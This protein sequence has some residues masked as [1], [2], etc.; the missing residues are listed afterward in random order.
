[1]FLDIVHLTNSINLFESKYT[2]YIQ[3]LIQDIVELSLLSM[4][5]ETMSYETIA[6]R[7]IIF[8]QN[9]YLSTL[10]HQASEAKQIGKTILQICE[11]VT[12]FSAIDRVPRYCKYKR[13]NDAEHSFMLA[14]AGIEIGSQYYP[15]LDTGL[16]GK[17]ALVHDFPEL[18]TGDVATFDLT[19]EQLSQK[20]QNE[21]QELPELLRSL[22]PHLADLL[23]I[24]EEQTLPEAQF[25]KHLDKLLPN[26]V[27][28]VGAG[29]KVMKEDYNVT[30]ATEFF[31]KNETLEARFKKTFN[32]P[33]HQPLHL[34]H[35][36]LAN[37]FALQFDEN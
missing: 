10:E 3:T 25:I 17:L 32:N 37:R 6:A 18:K 34:A 14:L 4:K 12:D 22:P 7:S 26:A 5:E 36:F 19:E 30:S 2:I 20:H 27:N 15:G 11:L 28:N 23:M 29:I 1:M 35:T 33:T 13:E 16:I 9:E 24:Y 8:D 21:A 31:I